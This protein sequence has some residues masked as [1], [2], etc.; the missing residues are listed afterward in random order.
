M[1][2][3]TKRSV[4]VAVDPEVAV[5][6]E[7]AEAP[8]CDS[9]AISVQASKAPMWHPFQQ[10]WIDSLLPADVENDSWVQSQVEAGLLLIIKG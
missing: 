9:E 7:V 1:A 6:P 4:E 10:V 5:E 3:G 8:V 2:R